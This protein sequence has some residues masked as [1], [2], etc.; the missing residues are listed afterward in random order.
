MSLM[1]TKIIITT[2]Y[3]MCNNY[4]IYI[5]VYIYIKWIYSCDSTAELLLLLLLWM[6][7]TGFVALYFCG[8]CGAFFQGSLMK[9]RKNNIYLKYFV[10]LYMSLLQLSRK[11]LHPCWIVC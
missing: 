5:N 6:L 10:T 1:L 3:I 11:L 8:I 9:N 4:I 7:T 2:L